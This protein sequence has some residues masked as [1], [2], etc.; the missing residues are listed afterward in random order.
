MVTPTR[1]PERP[2]PRGG[3]VRLKPEQMQQFKA[4]AE[5]WKQSDTDLGSRLVEFMASLDTE[6]QQ[7]ILGLPIPDER[8]GPTA[9]RLADTLARRK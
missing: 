3:S 5:R 2:Q 6:C 8:L 1:E 7:L 4:L 9:K